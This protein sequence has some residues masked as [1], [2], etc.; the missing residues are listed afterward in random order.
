MERYVVHRGVAI[1]E[2]SLGKTTFYSANGGV[3]SVLGT[4]PTAGQLWTRVVPLYPSNRALLFYEA[5][6]GNAE[7]LD[8]GVSNLGLSPTPGS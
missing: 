3:M 4:Q 8:V 1:Y 5:S 6:T 2:A 7:Y